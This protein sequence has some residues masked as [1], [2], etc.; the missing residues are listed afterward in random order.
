MANR[1]FNPLQA[2]HPELKVI[3]GSFKPNGA[4][5]VD[6][7]SREGRGWKVARSGAGL[8]TITLEDSFIALVAALL[9]LQLTAGDDKAVQLGDVDLSAKTIKI[10]VWD[11]S[12]AA[13]TDV[14]AN[15]NNKIHF[16]FFFRNTDEKPVRGKA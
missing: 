16:A 10:R 3:A 9:T 1:T 2:L 14:A 15:A 8:F 4:G 13:E 6:A 11:T 5:A 7:D 12:G